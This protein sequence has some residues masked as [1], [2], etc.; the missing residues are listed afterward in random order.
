MGSLS[1]RD[2]KVMD[3][4]YEWVGAACVQR[5]DTGNLPLLE[6]FLPVG[7]VVWGGVDEVKRT[8]TYPHR[9]NRTGILGIVQPSKT[10]SGALPRT[11]P[12]Q[13]ESLV[14]SLCMFPKH[15]NRGCSGY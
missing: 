10:I 4:V 7:W 15:G 11:S 14:L 1:A 2:S 3:I 8:Q 12:G 13:A 6:G 5:I 9:G